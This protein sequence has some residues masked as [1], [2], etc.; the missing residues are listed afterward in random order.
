MLGARRALLVR[1]TG[2]LCALTLFAQSAH[3]HTPAGDATGFLSGLR[4]PLSGLD[5]VLAMIAVGLWGA[6]LGSPAIWLLPV[7]FPMVMAFGGLLGLLGVPLPGVEFGIAGQDGLLYSIGFVIA[8][9]CLHGVG[10]GI[11]ALHRWEWGQRVM[12]LAGATVA[13]GG[14]VFLWKAIAR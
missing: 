6:Q 7:T 12:R 13:A 11:G 10:I 8:T 14:A 5:H 1:W 9:G 2:V 3:A 4:H